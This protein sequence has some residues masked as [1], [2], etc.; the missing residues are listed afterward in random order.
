MNS[1]KNH[2]L[3]FFFFISLAGYLVI[4]YGIERSNFNWL[5]TVFSV[6]FLIYFLSLKWTDNTQKVKFAVSA[7]VIFRISLLFSF[8]TLS[9]DFYRFI[10]DG[11]LLAHSINP[12]AHVPAFYIQNGLPP[13]L[14]AELFENLNSQTRYTVYPPVHQFIFWLS[15]IIG[16]SN[17]LANIAVMKTVIVAFEI[18]TFWVIAKLLRHFNLPLKYLLVYALNPLV[19]LELSGNLH[20]EGVMIFFLLASFYLFFKKRFLAASLCFLL[21]INTKLIPLILLPYLVFSLSWKKSVKLIGIV[22]A[23]T[24]ILHIPFFGDGFFIHFG[25]SLR[26]WFQSFEFNASIYYI[27]RWIGFQFTGYNIIQTAAPVLAVTATG[28]IVFVSWRMRNASL[29]NLPVVFISVLTIYLLFSTTVHPWYI[30][31]LIAFVPLTGLLFPLAWSAVIP[32][33]YIAYTTP[34]YNENLWFVA[35]E[36]TVLFALVMYDYRKKGFKSTKT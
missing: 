12:F 21:A 23:G 9:D 31:P 1:S 20:F 5:I 13:F 24:V 19:I 22:F 11:Q 14:S 36:Y 18:G 8:P 4:G 26:L 25:N 35:L 32:L 29:K 15:A 16:G 3:F 7:A 2:L 27:I 17:I 10:W 33:T 28:L 30:I 34:A 6:L